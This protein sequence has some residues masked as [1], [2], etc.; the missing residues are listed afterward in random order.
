MALLQSKRLYPTVGDIDYIEEYDYRIGMARLA[1]RDK[2]APSMMAQRSF[3]FGETS[4]YGAL[5]A[6]D[7]QFAAISEYTNR[8]LPPVF[9]LFYNAPTI[10][11]LVQVPLTS[12][13]SVDRDPLLGSR[14]V[15]FRGVADILGE[16]RKGYSPT[17]ADLAGEMDVFDHGWRLEHFMADLLLSCEE[18]WRFTEADSDEMQTLFYR[19]SGPIAATVAVTV[20]VPD[21]AELPK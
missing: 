13:V 16:A 1:Q 17:I 7:N 14:V 21:R 11:L 2:H 9:Y 18:G 20:E 10:P 15:P 4:R 6:H 12:R 3:V 8:H 19:R 5:Q